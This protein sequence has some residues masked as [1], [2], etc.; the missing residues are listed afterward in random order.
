MSHLL[1]NTGIYLAE[2]RNQ[3]SM[4]LIKTSFFRVENGFQVFRSGCLSFSSGFSVSFSNEEAPKLW[5]GSG[6]LLYCCT[7]RTVPGT[8]HDGVLRKLGSDQFHELHEMLRIPVGH[9]Q[10]NELHLRQG[11]QDAA[12]L[13]QV[14]LPAARTHRHMLRRDKQRSVQSS[15]D[16]RWTLVHP[17]SWRTVQWAYVTHEPHESSGTRDPSCSV[18]TVNM[19]IA[20]N[21]DLGCKIFLVNK[22]L[23]SPEA[24]SLA[25]MPLQIYE[26]WS[27]GCN[28]V[29]V[30]NLQGRQQEI[31]EASRKNK[32]RPFNQ[33]QSPGLHRMI[34][35]REQMQ[36][37]R[38]LKSLW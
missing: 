26:L 27:Y 12:H 6:S 25:S 32:G 14:R 18:P 37:G 24:L 2:G 17:D 22:L 23:S 34:P 30:Q 36:R 13:V 31:W 8:Y 28:H 29:S 5:K 4:L 38:C 10:A 21:L 19:H 20:L 1:R 33:G 16:H 35:H 3:H 15:S 9:I 7:L 11:L